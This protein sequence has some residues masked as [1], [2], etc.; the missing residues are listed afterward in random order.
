M[1]RLVNCAWYLA[2]GGLQRPSAE[3]TAQVL[4]AADAEDKAAFD[5]IL[6]K[7]TSTQ[8][9]MKLNGLFVTFQKQGRM[10]GK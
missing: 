7:C 8:D 2:V 4:H 3:S 1:N 5:F 9:A 6:S 10:K